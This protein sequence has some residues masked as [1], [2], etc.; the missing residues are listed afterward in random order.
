MTV[1][2][3][4]PSPFLKWEFWPLTS[5]KVGPEL[6]LVFIETAKEGDESIECA[7]LSECDRT[8]RHIDDAGIELAH[9]VEHTR[10]RLIEIP[11]ARIP[12][13]REQFNLNGAASRPL[14]REMK[15]VPREEWIG[16]GSGN[17]QAHL[18]CREL[19]R[20]RH[21]HIAAAGRQQQEQPSQAPYRIRPNHLVA[22]T[23]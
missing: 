14:E 23:F 20:G 10:S 21:R 15:I 2:R 13:I 16:G 7:K 12:R 4:S 5:G 19:D 8:V 22:G 18:I 3:P 9:H 17:R 6:L 11:S 1:R